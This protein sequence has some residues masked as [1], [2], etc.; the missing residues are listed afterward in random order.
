MSWNVLGVILKIVVENV[1][2]QAVVFAKEAVMGVTKIRTATQKEQVCCECK[3]IIKKGEKYA[4]TDI[5]L[6]PPKPFPT[7]KYCLPCSEKIA[8]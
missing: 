5:K 3:K 7:S 1:Y 6:A 4:D 2:L 8:K